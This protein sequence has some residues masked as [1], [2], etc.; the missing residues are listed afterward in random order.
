MTQVVDL[1]KK[2]GKQEKKKPIELKFRLCADGRIDDT[3]F[4]PL[5]HYDFVALYQK[6][7]GKYECDKILAWDEGEGARSIF[8]GH[9]NDGVVE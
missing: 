1:F 6:N 3:H 8:L 7:N 9:W 5:N 4:E 2:E